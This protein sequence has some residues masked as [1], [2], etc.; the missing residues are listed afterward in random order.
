M[1]SYFELSIYISCTFHIYTL[2]NTK[3]MKTTQKFLINICLSFLIFLS[4][5]TGTKLLLN[6]AVKGYTKATKQGEKLLNL[7]SLIPTTSTSDGISS[8]I[9][10][11]YLLKCKLVSEVDSLCKSIAETI[12]SNKF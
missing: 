2:D 10:T 4:I 6:M 5:T 9:S 1:V 11:T 3:L 7:T 12:A 8:L